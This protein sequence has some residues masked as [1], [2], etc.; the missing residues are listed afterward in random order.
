MDG[1]AEL[2]AEGAELVHAGLSTKAE[3]E[4]VAL[5][6]LDGAQAVEQHVAREGFGALLG[7][8][9][10]EGNDHSGV[11]AGGGEQIETFGER[12][13]DEA[14]ARAGTQQMRGMRLEGDGDGAGVKRACAF[15]DPRQQKTMA[16]VNAVVVADAEDGGAVIVRQI[17]WVVFAR[18]VEDLHG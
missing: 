9:R 11:D 6:H 17:G 16:K 5:M 10:G 4:V 1:E 8:F 13:R 7:E 2:L 3:A 18:V 14:W 12:G 15:N